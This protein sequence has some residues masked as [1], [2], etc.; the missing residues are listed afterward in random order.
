MKQIKIIVIVFVFMGILLMTM[1]FFS[2][3]SI[4][5]QGNSYV[6]TE[7]IL[8]SVDQFQNSNIVKS[9]LFKTI[10]NYLYHTFPEFNTIQIK[11]VSLEKIKIIVTEKVPWILCVANGKSWLLSDDGTIIAKESASI[12]NQEDIL[13]IKGLSDTY[14]QKNSISKPFLHHLK[15]FKEMLTLH[16]K[17]VPVLIET[18]GLNHINILLD[19]EVLVYLGAFEGADKKL[20]QLKAFLKTMNDDKLSQISYIDLRVDKKVFVKYGT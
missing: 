20:K 14:F 1:P 6:E 4:E 3:K 5:V 10:K 12:I 2:V 9:V 18:D 11:L 15:Q 19:D 8:Q 17:D 13:I 16:F 7:K